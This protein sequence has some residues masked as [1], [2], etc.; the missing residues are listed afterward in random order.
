LYT[1]YQE[2]VASCLAIALYLPG[3][4]STSAV[5]D[6]TEATHIAEPEP[7]P[8]PP[9]W[10]DRVI[11]WVRALPGPS[12]LFYLALG[13]V[14]ILSE[15][16]IKWIEGT[17]PVGTINP[18]H[19]MFAGVGVYAFGA[20]HYLDD[21]AERAIASFRPA[22]T[23][24]E[25]EYAQ[26]RYRLTTL[27]AR[28]TGILTL[29]MLVAVAAILLLSSRETANIYA[30]LKLY[31]SPLSYVVEG[32]ALL[33]WGATAGPFIYHVYHQI[34]VIDLIYTRHTAINLFH[35]RPLY[36]FSKLSAR[37]ALILIFLIYPAFLISPRVL[38]DPI[39]WV[40]SIGISLI[41][42]CTF[43]GPLLGIHKILDAEKD[44]LHREIATNIEEVCTRIDRAIASGNLDN[45]EQMK[46]ALEALVTRQDRLENT[47]TWPWHVDTPRVIGTAFLVPVVLY[48]IQVVID[49][50]VD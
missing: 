5:T 18:F 23:M 20:M 36:A 39:I 29:F 12:W 38:D 16:V 10:V 3:H 42:L 15:F 14:L 4:M 49:R 17:Y 27:P 11:D 8:Y 44:G 45:I 26:L 9:S 7:L 24:S 32:I 30:S 28:T 47:P 37:T 43:L 46:I 22:L 13:T 48:V 50:L 19:A 33:I 31:T 25:R 1:L 6:V 34:Q 2:A 21:Y 40:S 41:A 35:L